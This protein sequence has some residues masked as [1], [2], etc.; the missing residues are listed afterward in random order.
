MEVGHFFIPGR[1]VHN[2]HLSCLRC[3]S[4]D[5]IIKL[6]IY[7]INKMSQKKKVFR[8]T[9]FLSLT[10]SYSVC[11]SKKNLTFFQK[12]SHNKRKHFKERIF[13]TSNSKKESPNSNL[14]HY[15]IFHN[16]TPNVRYMRRSRIAKPDNSTLLFNKLLMVKLVK[17]LIFLISK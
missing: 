17:S 2:C 7:S 9:V 6:N 16:S 10:I 3:F 14:Y 5:W 1:Y 4:C 8:H 15:S 13:R 11:N 12:L